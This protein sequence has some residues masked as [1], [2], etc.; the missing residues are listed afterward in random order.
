MWLL[1]LPLPTDPSLLCLCVQWG[2]HQS[3]NI[4]SL[5]A[6]ERH[7]KEGK[8]PE[9]CSLIKCGYWHTLPQNAWQV[10]A[11][12]KKSMPSAHDSCLSAS[13]TL[14]DFYSF[15]Q[16]PWFH[17]Q[18][19]PLLGIGL[20]NTFT[21]NPTASVCALEIEIFKTAGA[22]QPSCPIQMLRLLSACPPS[23]R[24]TSE[25][26]LSLHS[27]QRHCNKVIKKQRWLTKA[28]SA[29]FSSARDPSSWALNWGRG[30][31]WFQNRPSLLRV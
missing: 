14:E 9:T 12:G 13:Q 6:G 16:T 27:A 31:T 10:Q 24:S 11:W 25:T 21:R 15:L 28:N 29:C 22:S 19:E 8:A 7:S 5:G 23:T 30:S 1:A 3:V 26:P 18:R 2:K 17:R 20:K 4:L